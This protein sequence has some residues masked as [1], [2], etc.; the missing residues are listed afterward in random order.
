MISR[1]KALPLLIII[2]LYHK[3]EKEPRKPL[4]GCLDWLKPVNTSIK[5]DRRGGRVWNLFIGY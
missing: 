3:D 1:H 2:T 4:S 5:L